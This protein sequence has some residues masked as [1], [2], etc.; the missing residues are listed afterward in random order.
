[1]GHAKSTQ[2][3]TQS[4]QCEQYPGESALSE[5]ETEVTRQAMLRWGPHIF[6]S[7]HSG[8]LAMF[9]PFSFAD[10]GAIL[11]MLALGCYINYFFG[12]HLLLVNGCAIVQEAV[13][14]SDLSRWAA[15][16]ILTLRNWQCPNYNW[17]RHRRLAPSIYSQPTWSFS[18]HS[19]TSPEPIQVKFKCA[20]SIFVRTNLKFQAND[21]PKKTY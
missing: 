18:Q 9:S 15:A 6:L 11:Q 3:L 12:T 7:I 1:M 2:C 10:R 4:A 17:N 21:E 5:W 20:P 8:T 14:Y 19:V 16:A 13:T